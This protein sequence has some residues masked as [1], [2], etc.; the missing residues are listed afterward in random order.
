MKCRKSEVCL[1][2]RVAHIRL[3]GGGG[4]LSELAEKVKMASSVWLPSML[5]S[6]QWE[7]SLHH[8]SA[9]LSHLLSLDSTWL[10]RSIVLWLCERMDSWQIYELRNS[11]FGVRRNYAA[12]ENTQ[13]VPVWSESILWNMLCF[14]TE[15]TDRIL[16]LVQQIWRLE[17]AAG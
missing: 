17:Q 7:L 5:F 16:V 3:S 14:H 11:L 12:T 1:W 6:H 15:K 13:K 4:S 9:S 8:L 2:E 10:F